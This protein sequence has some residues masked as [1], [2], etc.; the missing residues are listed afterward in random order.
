MRTRIAKSIPV[1]A[2]AAAAALA[3]STLDVAGQAKAWTCNAPG[4]LNSSYSGGDTAYIHLSGFQTG[5][6]YK[7]AK[8]GNVATGKTA[9]GTTFTCKS[10]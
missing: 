8:K 4:L 9:N 3:A 10:S 7:V 5:G 2:G 6:V 1:V